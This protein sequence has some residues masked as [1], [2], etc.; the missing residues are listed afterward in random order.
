MPALGMST[1]T[2]R[3]TATAMEPRQ[4]MLSTA[5]M[6]RRSDDV[7]LPIMGLVALEVVELLR[8]ASRQ[9]SVVTMVRVIPVVDVPMEPARPMEPRPG[10]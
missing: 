1:T 3:P 5:P 8:T 9:R 10:T 2:S 7:P 6:V 4:R